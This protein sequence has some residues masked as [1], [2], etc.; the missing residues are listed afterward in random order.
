MMMNLLPAETKEA[1]KFARWN[2]SLIQYCAVCLVVLA[3]L[4]LIFVVGKQNS[5]STIKYLEKTVSDSEARA[6]EL[7][8]VQKEAS[9]LSAKISTINQ[10]FTKDR[11]YG[12]ILQRIGSSLPPGASINGIEL[13]Q[14]TLGSPLAITINTASYEVS[15]QAIANLK[16][17]TSGLFQS[18]DLESANCNRSAVSGLP[19]SISIKATFPKDEVKK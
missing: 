19:C 1:I 9:D 2:Y 13:S 3:G 10:L 12:A 18:V 14:K 17:K 7:N 16:D 8:A 5:D 6:S 15:V 11:D 4:A